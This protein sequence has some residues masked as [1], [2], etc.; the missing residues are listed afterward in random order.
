[1]S[2]IGNFFAIEEAKAKELMSNPDSIEEFIYSEESPID[3]SENFLDIDKSWH[4]IHFIL[5]NN[6][7]E[8]E[9]PARD[10]ILGGEAVG[11][12]VGYGPARFLS[13]EEVK[14]V[15]SYLSGINS[16]Y[17]KEKYNPEELEKNE[18]YPNGWGDEDYDYLVGYFED[19]KKFYEKAAS[20]N[21]MV[22]QYLN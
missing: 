12:D 15:N 20:E 7:W 9:P 16:N 10:V 5:T 3:E 2:M 11:E 17:I 19:L 8:G 14:K 6:V 18:I 1:M 22:I 13:V 4:G 21:K